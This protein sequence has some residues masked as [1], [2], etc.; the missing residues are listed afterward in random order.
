[1][2]ATEAAAGPYAELCHNLADWDTAAAV[3]VRRGAGLSV[4]EPGEVEAVV[5]AG[6]SARTVIGVCE[7]AAGKRVRWMVIQ[8]AQR[9]DQMERWLC[10]QRWIV[11]RVLEV[12]ERRRRYPT[13]LVEVPG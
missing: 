5:V 9:P 12:E 6:L 4:L 7:Q 11:R 2:V 3:E 13:W 10:D 8:C 1:V